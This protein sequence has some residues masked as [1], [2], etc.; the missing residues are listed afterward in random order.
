[1]PGPCHP[2]L[3]RLPLALRAE[4]WH[5]DPAG[6]KGRGCRT[7]REV[8]SLTSTRCFPSS[9]WPA[10]PTQGGARASSPAPRVP[11]DP[12]EHLRP[13][14][15]PP[16]ARAA[17]ALKAPCREE[18][19]AESGPSPWGQCG[20]GGA[21]WAEPGQ[22]VWPGPLTTSS[23]PGHPCHLGPPK[24]SSGQGHPIPLCPLPQRVTR[25]QGKEGDS[26][27]KALVPTHHTRTLLPSGPG[28][29]Q[30]C[31]WGEGC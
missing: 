5:G 7:A 31:L 30:G 17:V 19:E 3:L 10:T 23:S 4:R 16:V 14:E 15:P 1:M 13:Q 22:G 26:L 20:V 21:A 9:A 27:T 18:V 12:Q 28:R 11:A 29:D 25:P 6:P 2:R 8:G 24:A